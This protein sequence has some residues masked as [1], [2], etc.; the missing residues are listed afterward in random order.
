MANLK[1]KD[2]A[3]TDFLTAGRCQVTLEVIEA[4]WR[5]AQQLTAP[6]VA[7]WKGGAQLAGGQAAALE[8]ALR[9][10][11][12]DLQQQAPATA[13]AQTDRGHHHHHRRQLI[14]WFCTMTNREGLKKQ[15]QNLPAILNHKNLT[16][17]AGGAREGE[18]MA[19]LGHINAN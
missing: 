2:S 1:D 13:V 17:L 16:G 7:G 11:K 8:V 14:N 15:A 3:L 18:N 5:R 6:A 19:H 10:K 4:S 12:Y 9:R